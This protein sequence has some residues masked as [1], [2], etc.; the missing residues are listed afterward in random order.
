VIRAL[1]LAAALLAVL[2]WLAPPGMA[3]AETTVAVADLPALVAA[4]KAARG[5]EVLL[6]EPGD[7]GRLELAQGPDGSFAWTA[8]V[9]LRP[10]DP[11]RPPR[12]GEL[13]LRG[14]GD[15]TFDGLIFDHE[16]APGQDLDRRIFQISDARNITIRNSVFDGDIVTQGAPEDIGLPSGIALS[17]PRVT[18]ARVEDNLFFHFYRAIA[19]GRGS[20]VLLRGNE[21][22]GMRMDGMVFTSM[23]DVRI[24]GNFI[25]GFLR[26]KVKSDHS[27][28]IQFWTRNNTEATRG[29]TI[30]GN[31]LLAGQGGV[32][33]SIFMRND[34]VDR[35]LAGEELFYRDILI[36]ENVIVNGHSNA[37]VLGEALGATIRNNTL[38]RSPLF[39]QGEDRDRSVR[40]PRIRLA[41]T[42]REVT[43]EGNIA[44]GVPAAQPGWRVEGNLV[45][46]D[47]NPAAP[48]YYS[49]EVLPRLATGDPEHLETYVLGPGVVAGADLLKS[50]H[51]LSAF[52]TRA[53]P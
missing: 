51:D 50:G 33:Q 3:R 2:G 35:G 37:I 48:G 52:R 7:Y 49:A 34:M 10:A 26:S 13:D 21:I 6:L 31:V 32:T 43:V 40:V 36:E 9:T 28:M 41:K 16:I 39:A 14:I 23:T 25:H 47:R 8:P 4:L 1:P 17:L 12:L 24:E 22:A 19:M 42:S 18:G 27:D 45:L 5:G 38:L 30:R 44:G 29:I 46:Q 53:L 20:D 15:L 11:A